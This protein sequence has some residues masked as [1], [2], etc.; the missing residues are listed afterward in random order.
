LQTPDT[1]FLRQLDAFAASIND[2]A[3]VLAG[4]AGVREDIISLQGIAKAIARSAGQ[5]I[6][7]E[8]DLAFRNA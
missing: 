6:I 2:G 5:E 1:G 4:L 3:P 7:T 8:A